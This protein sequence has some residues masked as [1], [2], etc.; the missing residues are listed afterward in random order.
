MGARVGQG[1]AG[2]ESTIQGAWFKEFAYGGTNFANWA[3]LAKV[4]PSNP[5]GTLIQM[6]DINKFSIDYMAN[7][8]NAAN[9]TNAAIQMESLVI[10]APE[11]PPVCLMREI[12]YGTY[13]GRTN[14]TVIQR[15]AAS[16]APPTPNSTLLR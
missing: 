9:P 4:D 14:L 10:L 16:T 2:P 8:P 1:Q 7:Y 13:I 5:K 15:I 11:A 3:M 12:T 6:R